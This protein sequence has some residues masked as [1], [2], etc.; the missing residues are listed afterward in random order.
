MQFFVG[1]IKIGTAVFTNAQGGL[2]NVDLVD[3]VPTWSIDPPE[4]A[5]AFELTPV[6]GNPLQI[7]IR[8]LDVAVGWKLVADGADADLDPG[9][10]RALRVESEMNDTLPLEAV[11]GTVNIG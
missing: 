1:D 5:S 9:E 10:I 4:M 3:Q 6:E 8:M 2:A 7:G 11:A